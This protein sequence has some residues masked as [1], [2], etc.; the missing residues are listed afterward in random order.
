MEFMADYHFIVHHCAG[1]FNIAD[2]LS[3]TP[4]LELNGIEYSLVINPDTA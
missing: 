4:G 2:P 3:G 1:K